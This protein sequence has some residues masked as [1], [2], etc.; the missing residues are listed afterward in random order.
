MPRYLAPCLLL[1]TGA[2]GHLAGQAPDRAALQRLLVAEDARGQGADGIAPLTANLSSR[3]TLLRRVAVRAIGRLQRPD[4]GSALL[5]ALA[6]PVRDI[7]AEAAIAIAQSLRGRPRGAPPGGPADLTVP[8]AHEVLTAAIRQ[9]RDD[10]VAGVIAEA[11]GRLLLTDS[12]QGRSAEQAILARARGR[13]DYGMAHGLFWLA[14]ARRFSGGLSEPALAALREAALSSPDSN[15]RRMAVLTLGRAGGLD[16]ATT[17]AASRDRDPQVRRLA[18]AGVAGLSPEHRAEL[19][20]KALADSSVIVRVAAVTAARAG[21]NPPDCS[22][23]MT[24]LEDHHPYVILAALDAMGQ[25]CANGAAVADVLARVTGFGEAA[26]ETDPRGWQAN[27][28]A[29]VALSRVDSARAR[30]FLA[31]FAGSRLW[32]KR[33]YAARAAAHLRDRATLYVLARD[34]DRNVREAAITGLASVAGHEADTTYLAA[35]ADEGNQVLL[36]AGEALKGSTD[37]RALPVILTAFD[38]ISRRRSENARDPR[39]ALLARIG[40]LGTSAQAERLR[41]YLADFDSAVAQATAE[42]LSRWSG[43]P[44]EARPVPLPITPEPLAGYFLS[45]NL[46]LRVTMARGSGGG[47]FVIRLFP[48]ETPATVARVVRRARENYY[49]GHL[50]QRVEP[51]FVIQGGGPDASEYVGD[52]AFMRD[53][54]GFHS[55]YRGTLGISTRGRDTGDAQVFI[56]LVDNPL[57]D[58]EFTVFGQVVEGM[59]VVDRILEGDE[60][61]RVE[62]LE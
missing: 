39:L 18:L 55:H 6:D 10:S 24:A 22:P 16:T 12:L 3:D 25:P 42:L 15:L 51:N 13:M 31:T 60:I 2:A 37:S 33:L 43:S 44:V 19:V 11:L 38:R 35:L 58:H 1:I 4:L 9:E 49:S 36:A 61:A 27:A 26:S 48:R 8:R 52:D 50:F 5:P 7:R 59:D 62:V 45:V 29:L 30:P 54:L 23:L 40:E 28:H 57:L 14:L 20:R 46:R 53:E 32:Q 56:N 21:A 17:L 34:S 41:P 47:S